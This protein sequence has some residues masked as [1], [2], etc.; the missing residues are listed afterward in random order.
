P[1]T[2]WRGSSRS[3]LPLPTTASTSG[4]RRVVQSV[5]KPCWGKLP[6]AYHYHHIFSLALSRGLREVGSNLR[7]WNSAAMTA[8]LP[9]IAEVRRASERLAG[10]SNE[11]PLLES[12]VLNERFG[13]RV[14][15]KAETLLRTGSFKFRRAYNK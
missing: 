7:H 15:F 10:H 5:R 2:R 8:S 14:F 6:A 3:P 13:G 1:A 11:T 9:G 4:E 12:P